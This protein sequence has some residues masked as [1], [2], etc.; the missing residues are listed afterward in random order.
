[1][2]NGA[3]LSAGEIFTS[4]IKYELFANVLEEKPFFLQVF[5]LPLVGLSVKTQHVSA[6]GGGSAKYI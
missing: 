1:M 5:I 4:R 2:D 6:L 3:N